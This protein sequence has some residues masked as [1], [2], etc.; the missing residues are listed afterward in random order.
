MFDPTS[1][2][3]GHPY[4]ITAQTGYEQ[5]MITKTQS[6]HIPHEAGSRPQSLH[7]E[8]EAQYPSAFNPPQT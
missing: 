7:V 3:T 2:A 1:A 5:R 8:D 6:H 4:V